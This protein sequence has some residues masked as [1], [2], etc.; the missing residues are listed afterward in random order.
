MSP[1]G[2]SKDMTYELCDSDGTFLGSNNLKL[3]NS[4]RLILEPIDWK[5]SRM[6]VMVGI[7]SAV[8][9]WQGLVVAKQ[10]L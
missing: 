7:S 1:L 8:V 3:T 10:D 5:W 6:L 2:D 9:D 4:P